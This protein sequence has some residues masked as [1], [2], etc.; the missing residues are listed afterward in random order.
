MLELCS[1]DVVVK[2]MAL[3]VEEGF[4]LVTSQWV[5]VLVVSSLDVAVTFFRC[6]AV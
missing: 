3:L 6:V 4:V 1:L 2:W 5:T